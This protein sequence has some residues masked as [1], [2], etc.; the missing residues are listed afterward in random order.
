MIRPRHAVLALLPCLAMAPGAAP[1]GEADQVFQSLYGEEMRRVLSTRD[2]DDDVALARKLLDAA[3][4]AQDQPP[5]LAVLCEK[6]HFLGSR[7]SIGFATAIDALGLLAEKLPDRKKDCQEKVLALHQ[8]RYATSRGDERVSAAHVLV[9]YLRKLARDAEETSDHAAATRHLRR[10]SYVAAAV[11]SQAR[12]AIQDDLKR[13]LAAE[14]IAREIASLEKR[15]AQDGDDQ[16]ARSRLLWLLLVERDDPRQAAKHLAPDAKEEMRTYL[17]LVAR[18]AAELPEGAC[19]EV[20]DWYRSLSEKASAAG[21]TAMLRRAKHYYRLFLA[22]H[23]TQ[24]MQRTKAA[25][26]LKAIDETLGEAAGAETETGRAAPGLDTALALVSRPGKL[27]GVRQ[28]TLETRLPRGRLLTVAYSPDGR[29]L[30]IATDC[31]NIRLLEA[32]TGRLLRVLA[33]H[34]GGVTDL[35][36]SPDGAELVSAC[37]GRS[38]RV[39]EAKTGR[40]IRVLSAR[41]AVRAVAMSPDGAM[42]AAAGRDAAVALWKVQTGLPAGLLRGGHKAAVARLAWSPDGKWIASAGERGDGGICV[43]D[44]ATKRRVHAV[45]CGS[46]AVVALAWSPDGKTLA[47]VQRGKDDRQ[48]LLWDRKSRKVIHSL[49]RD[50]RPASRALAWSPDGKRLA[51]QKGGQGIQVVQVGAWQSLAETALA[52]GVAD[53]A[54]S[55]DGAAIAMCSN[56]HPVDAIVEVRVRDSDPGDERWTIRARVHDM[57]AMAWEPATRKLAWVDSPDRGR[58]HL[59]AGWVPKGRV[60]VGKGG[61]TRLAWSPDGSRLA[62]SDGRKSIA[63][64]DVDTARATKALSCPDSDSRVR[65]LAWSRDGKRLLALAS[66]AVPPVVVFE[67]ATGKVARAYKGPGAPSCLAMA[68]SPDG[69]LLAVIAYSG[70]VPGGKRLWLWNAA[71]GRFLRELAAPGRNARDLSWAPDS[72]MLVTASDEKLA[73][74]WNLRTGRATKVLG[75]ARHPIEVVAWSPDGKVIAA[76]ENPAGGGAGAIR[77]WNVRARRTSG[78]LRGHA[79]AVRNLAWSRDGRKLLSAG[80]RLLRLWD[81]PALRPEMTVL[82]VGAFGDVMVRSDGHF[83]ASENVDAEKDLVY[84]VTTESGQEVLAPSQFAAKY[85]WKNDPNQVAR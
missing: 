23:T 55:P 44:A 15:L 24:D 57:A 16:A 80:E 5:L 34:E 40:L 74:V 21:R 72:R 9:D 69:K 76:A 67:V 85:G 45:D 31:G 48:V 63:V 46:S 51:W 19:L 71:S 18:D 4:Q 27:K 30:A 75:D 14:R 32:A 3:K 12:K 35:A 10:A 39:W 73:V 77:L 47:F 42:L 53:L 33:G 66:G 26:A 65:G 2:A 11:R 81:V 60:P 36:F 58:C 62:A 84:V 49:A 38:I 70:R 37:G 64:L 20:A 79:T 29:H 52:Y 59:W 22:K 56:S 50:A 83:R 41:T 13:L 61:A 7:H 82:P 28:W 54:W 25:L 1:A 68:P 43:W 6:T 17:P 8:R 78:V